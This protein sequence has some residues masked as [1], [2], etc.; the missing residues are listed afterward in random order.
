MAA[1]SG[2]DWRRLEA[3]L[4]S[5]L[6]RLRDRWGPRGSPAASP[7]GR[8]AEEA[9]PEEEEQPSALEALPIDVKLYIMSFLTSKDLSYLG[10]TNHYWRHT[11]RDPLLWRYLLIRDLP[12]WHSVDWKSLPDADIFNRSFTE[13]DDSAPC[14]YME[15]YKKCCSYSGHNSCPKSGWSNNDAKVYFLEWL[16][17]RSVPRFAMF[18]PGLEDLDE[19]LVYK[20]M[21]SPE[22]LPLAGLPSRQIHGIGSGVTFHVN[23]YQRINILTL[24]SKTSKERHRAREENPSPVNKMFCEEM[25]PD[26]TMRYNLIEHVKHMCGLIDGFIYV[27]DAEAHKK[28]NRAVECAR[29]ATMLDPALGPKDRPLLIL[30]C[31]SHAGMERIPC[32][33]M[34][35]QLQLNLL[36]Q[37]WMIQDAEAATL[38]GLLNGI[39]WLLGEI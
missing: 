12:S 36:N 19:S 30:S 13:L 4:R 5:S 23:G 33:Y 9:P 26:G 2:A 3:A 6:W 16:K 28:H 7:R 37:P 11:V 14:D 17:L 18:G 27:A 34:A 15:V 38:D 20:M 32:V 8:P 24:Y 35:H 39:E 22:I 29:M 25:G 31:I 10:S 1:G 21:T